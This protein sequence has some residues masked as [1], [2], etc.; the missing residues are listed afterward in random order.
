VA[1]EEAVAAAMTDATSPSH[2]L[3]PSRLVTPLEPLT[4]Y[5]KAS[6]APQRPVLE[7]A[8]ELMGRIKREFAYEPKSTAVSTPLLE[9]FERRAGVCQDFAHIM[10]A[11]LR[12]I[13]LPVAYVSG[14]IRTVPP[15]GK[16]RLEG[17]DAT[18][19][20]VSLWGGRQ[21]GW[22]DL[23]P[24]NNMMVGN[25]H[26]VLAVGRDYSD[27]SPIDGIIVGSGGQELDVKVDVTPRA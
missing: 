23:D 3:Y 5:A 22:V 9:A 27:V 18:H 12:G 16:P 20:W 25:D 6:F 8:R 10:I 13:G 7:G 1:R 4:R 11:G 15:P 14:Y 19:A 26:I 17:A 2:Y 24:T 21:L